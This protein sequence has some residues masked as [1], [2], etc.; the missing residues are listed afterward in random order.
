[1]FKLINTDKEDYV[2]FY[3]QLR[4]TVREVGKQAQD[5][6]GPSKVVTAHLIHSVIFGSE[7]S[8]SGVVRYNTS[9]FKAND[10]IECGSYT[11]DLVQAVNYSFEPI[12]ELVIAAVE[13]VNQIIDDSIM[14]GGHLEN[15]DIS[16]RVNNFIESYLLGSKVWDGYTTSCVIVAG[17][18]QQV[19]ITVV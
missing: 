6:A 10:Q 19:I 8:S 4:L 15:D 17:S 9:I 2:P 7:I 16:D 3:R 14:L 12:E 18:I 11:E 13:E 1:M 5:A